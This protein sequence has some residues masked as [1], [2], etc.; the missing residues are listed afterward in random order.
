MKDYRLSDLLDLNSIQRMA[1]AHYHAA[2]M[3][4]G[5]ID[6]FDG[7]ILVGSGWQDICLRFHRS[8]PAAL[9]R[10]QESDDYIKGS[11]VKGEACHYK[12]RNGLWDIGIPIVVN[13]RH[14]A[15]MFLGQFFYEAEVPDRQFFIRQA[16]EFGFD[17][18]GY[19]AALDRVPVLSREKVDSI[20]EYD[21]ALAGFISDLAEH[22]L[23]KIE[24]DEILHES[25]R[26][27]R[28][29][30]NQSHQFL[31]LLSV[32]GTVLEA[33]ASALVF[34]GVKET[35]V[36]G[37]PFWDTPWWTHS[38]EM[39]E[40][41]RQAVN[42]AAEGGFIRFEATHVAA[43]GS[44]HYIDFSLKP[45]RDEEG[46]VFLLIPEGRDITE[47]K[48]AEEE[49]KSHIRFLEN[50]ERIDQVIK[51]EADME[52]MLWNIVAT[53][54]SI[55]GCDRAWLLYP[56]D[57]SEPTFRVPVEISRPEYPGAHVLNLDV[58]MTA[59]VLLNIREALESQEP[60]VYIAGTERPVNRLT[61]D[62]FG[63]LSQMLTVLYPRRGKPWVFGLHQ[64]SYPRV[65]TQE[66]KKLFNEIA[67]RVSDGLSSVLFLR[68]LQE[69]E[70]RFRATFEQAAVGIAH[71]APD[72]RWLRVNQKLCD[73]MGYSREE[74]LQKTFQDVTWPEDLDKDLDLHRNVLEG[75]IDTYSLEKRY[76]H[77]SGALV[78]INLTISMVRSASGNP[79]HL[80][81]VVE[82]ITGRKRVEEEKQKLQ[83]QLLQAQKMES[84]GRL[85]GG[86][87]HDFN[88]MLGVILGNAELAMVRAD[89]DNPIR[90]N[91]EEIQ[92]AAE[93]SADLTR[94][95]LA[96]ARQQTVAPR[97]LD[98]NVTV[99]RMLNILSRLLGEEIELS[100]VPDP[101]L[102][103]VRIDPAQIDQILMNL[104]ANAR[105]SITGLGRVWIETK[106]MVADENFC[107]GHAGFHPG[108]YVMLAVRDSGSGMSPETMANIFEPFFT[109]KE[110]GK[111]TGLGLATVYG[112]VRQNNGLIN[113]QSEPG[114][115]TAFRIY[116]SKHGRRIAADGGEMNPT[117]EMKGSGT[118]LL[119][120]DEPMLLKLTQVMLESLGYTVLIAT[121]PGE[122]IRLV[123]EYA[124]GIDLL[125]TDVVMP[126]MNG[127]DLAG[128]L[129]SL[130]PELK[131]VF[132][133]GYTAD[134]IAHHGVLEEG[135]NFIQ[136]PFSIK[137]LA[138][139][140][141]EALEN[142]PS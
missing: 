21:K 22:E 80:I 101:D 5:I 44:L 39:Q 33:N 136:K 36:I 134:V 56:C 25:E 82:D 109:T 68:E 45:I 32:E 12:C 99:N 64:C 108:E 29:I 60:V 90:K 123:E 132:M 31:G 139:K 20:L 42:R 63:V 8:S 37:R 115:G 138:Q 86:V 84:V 3:P 75:K 19:L 7:S 130:Y 30:F 46:K 119:V 69:N 135:V 125:M 11:L 122:A 13:G 102:W 76:I 83:Y 87:A 65:W 105:D 110:R 40:K 70:E 118:V 107:A 111:G 95:L 15:T 100:W 4:I 27:F 112:I 67:R 66:E 73:I 53:V 141:R 51:Q 142:K 26:K 2:G 14:L 85:A 61:A 52:K 28:A 133:S 43:D 104:A 10:C 54:F 48:L 79:E 58:P 140:V 124:G 81:A 88:N 47:L 114:Q 131:S 6:A 72:G 94:Q 128:R 93:Y 121:T 77:K 38:P 97:V 57:P 129:L 91:I 113:V 126:E 18:D 23:R 127:R 24:T 55:F 34:S 71:V 1:D 35:D 92:K 89:R 17:L 50:L 74:L 59:D 16:D 116:F 78:W 9:Q 103:P 62:R 117:P 96:F 98:L 41:I 137:D 49:H 120:E 106:N